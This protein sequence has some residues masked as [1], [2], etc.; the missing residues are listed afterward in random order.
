M[1]I[2]FCYLTNPLTIEMRNNDLIKNVDK[3]EQYLYIDIDYATIDNEEA[4]LNHSGPIR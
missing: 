1:V 4:Y 2:P 3:G